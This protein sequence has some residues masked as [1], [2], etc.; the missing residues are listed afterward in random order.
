MKSSSS[1]VEKGPVGG[2]ATT[3]L[4][5]RSRV[6]YTALEPASSRRES[7]LPYFRIPSSF[8]G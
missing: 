2:S 7:V 5:K 1:T 3:V 4:Q 6:N 8:N